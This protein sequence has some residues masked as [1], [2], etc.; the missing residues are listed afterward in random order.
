MKNILYLIIILNKPLKRQL[1]IFSNSYFLIISNHI[2]NHPLI[3]F[4]L[5]ILYSYKK[6]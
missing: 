3:L 2:L 5:K 4:L 1:L 6:K